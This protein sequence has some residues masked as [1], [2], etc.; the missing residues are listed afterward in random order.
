ML[1]K[2]ANQANIECNDKKTTT[3]IQIKRYAKASPPLLRALNMHLENPLNR[4]VMQVG[5][6][7]WNFEKTRYF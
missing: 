7:Y 3:Q 5:S 1:R 2:Q 6:E 4:L